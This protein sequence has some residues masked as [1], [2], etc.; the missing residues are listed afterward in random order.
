MAIAVGLFDF[1]DYSVQRREDAQGLFE[2]LSES[3]ELVDIAKEEWDGFMTSTIHPY[4]SYLL[5]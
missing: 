1:H 5:Q 3:G 2:V 4:R